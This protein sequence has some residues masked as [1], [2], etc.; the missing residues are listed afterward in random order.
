MRVLYGVAPM[1]VVP[2]LLCLLLA[3]GC[4]TIERP[5]RALTTPTWVASLDKRSPYL[6]AHLRDGRVW[7][8]TQWVVH[9]A[10]GTVAGTGELLG[11]DRFVLEQRAVTVPIASVVL[12]ETN[13]VQKS[14]A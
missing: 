6:K 2:S 13:V 9:E 1:R 10:E 7:I 12:F 4:S 14:P 5:R 8:L 3:G 11:P